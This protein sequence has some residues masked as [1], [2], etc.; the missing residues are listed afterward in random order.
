MNYKII[1]KTNTKYIEVKQ[2]VTCESDILDIIGICISND[3]RLLLFK[4]ETF[5]EEF[6]N[7]KLGLAGIA[8]Q[9][10]I[11]YNIKVSAIIE[12]NKKIDGRF[13][14]LIYELNRSNNFRVFNNIEDAENWILNIK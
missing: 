8:L 12:D 2:P 1:D 5:T 14:E 3:I 10:F 11:N 4:E 6:F 13:G 9:K 7:L